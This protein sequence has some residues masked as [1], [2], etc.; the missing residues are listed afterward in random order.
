MSFN[1]SNLSFVCVSY[2]NRLDRMEEGASVPAFLNSNRRNNSD[3]M[4]TSDHTSQDYH[5]QTII[6]CLCLVAISDKV[7]L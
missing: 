4:S 3:H 1:L 6:N 5:L 2:S 7:I